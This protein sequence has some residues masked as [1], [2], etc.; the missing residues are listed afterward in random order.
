MSDILEQINS[1]TEQFSNLLEADKDDLKP[2]QNKAAKEV[3]DKLG[4]SIKGYVKRISPK[5]DYNELQQH[6]YRKVKEFATD[7]LTPYEKVKGITLE[8]KIKNSPKTKKKDEIE[9]H[10][11]EI[12]D[13]MKKYKTGD[14]SVAKSIIKGKKKMNDNNSYNEVVSQINSLTEQFSNLFEVEGLG[15][16]ASDVP[17]STNKLKRDIINPILGYIGKIIYV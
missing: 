16:P 5:R 1:L 6:K 12:Y 9:A 3:M 14:D 2:Y 13:L 17:P 4:L 10:R 15:D 7:Q 8:D 11:K